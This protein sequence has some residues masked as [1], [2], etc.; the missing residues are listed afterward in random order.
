MPDPPEVMATVVGLR[1][2]LG[3]EGRT[4]VESVTVPANPFT[5]VSWIVEVPGEPAKMVRDAELGEIVKSTTLTVI[6]TEWE[7]E[8]MV[9]VTVTT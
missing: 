4:E 6:W 7:R 9:P 2:A 3:P 8:P 1:V 5:L